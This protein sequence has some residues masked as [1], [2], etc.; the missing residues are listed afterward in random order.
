[1]VW[2]P[3]TAE[4]AR[5]SLP[6]TVKNG[7]WLK[8][9]RLSSHDD[10][11]SRQSLFDGHTPQRSRHANY[12]RWNIQRQ[13]GVPQQIELLFKG[14]VAEREYPAGDPDFCNQIISLSL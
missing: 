9:L 8:E 2:L 4:I 7:V 5:K 13:E 1:V 11:I 6:L 12:P 3:Q 14:L 10:R